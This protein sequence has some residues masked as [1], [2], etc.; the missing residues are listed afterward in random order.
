MEARIYA[1]DPAKGFLPSIGGFDVLML[2]ESERVDTGVEEGGEVSAFYDPM[3]AK[4]ISFGGQRGEAIDYLRLELSSLGAWPVKT[5]TRFLYN[6]LSDEDFRSGNVDTGLI[7]RKGDALAAAPAI[8]DTELTR[9][10]QELDGSSGIEPSDLDGF[11]LNGPAITERRLRIDGRQLSFTAG[12]RPDGYVASHFRHVPDRDAVL[13]IY[14]GASLLVEQDRTDRGSVGAAAGDGAILAPMP[15]KVT[16][17][18]VKAGETVA[19]GRRLLTLEAMKMEHALTAPFDGVVAEL[20]AAA[21]AQV[22]EGQLLVRV[23]PAEQ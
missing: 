3:I 23:E 9:A 7:E 13:M 12:S 2:P 4:V 5:N 19:K 21:G 11:R 18:D 10:L 16:S 20:N 22:T 14:A 1:E 15:G 8:P 17:V 6:L